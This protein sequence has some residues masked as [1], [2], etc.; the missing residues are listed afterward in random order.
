MAL[1]RYIR[2][3]LRESVANAGSSPESPKITF[4]DVEPRLNMGQLSPPDDTVQAESTLNGTAFQRSS[5]VHP[6][7]SGTSRSKIEL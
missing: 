1:S 4:D 7:R 3:R 6:P 2:G 5:P